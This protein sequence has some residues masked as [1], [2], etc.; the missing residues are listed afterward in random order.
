MKR[1]FERR[2]VHET[3]LKK[4]K[5]V[6]K[7]EE[8]QLSQLDFWN[9]E[10]G[11]PT[12]LLSYV[13]EL[14][15]SLERETKGVVSLVSTSLA[16]TGKE[17]TAPNNVVQDPDHKVS[18]DYYRVSYN[19]DIVKKETSQNSN[20]IFLFFLSR[21]EGLYRSPN[22]KTDKTYP[23]KPTDQR[24]LILENLTKEF[25]D[26]K[27]LANEVGT[28]PSKYRPQIKGLKVEIEEHFP[29]VGGDNFIISK[30]GEGYRLGDKITLKK[31]K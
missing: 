23:L 15:V 16:K 22:G 19:P 13:P 31:I 21:S 11:V 6:N 25:Q 30:R 17:V 2:I 18:T 14:I 3:I 5:D 9:P 29:E 28:V 20:D 1:E 12:L 27:K 7:T 8:I 26:T 24:F 4:I 10:L